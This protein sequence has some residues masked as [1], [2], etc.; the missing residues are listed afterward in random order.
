MSPIS[1]RICVPNLVAVRRS[2][3][4]K[5]GQT[6]RQREPA[7]L[8]IVDYYV[9]LNESL[10]SVPKNTS[11]SKMIKDVSEANFDHYHIVLVM[12]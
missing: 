10:S 7:A 11:L 4:K 9:Q 5:G 3:R 6:D 12:S 8:Y 2:C 1:T